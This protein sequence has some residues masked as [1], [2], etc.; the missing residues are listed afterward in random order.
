VV[1][2]VDDHEE[3]A[4]YGTLEGY[5]KAGASKTAESCGNSRAHL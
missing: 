5:L 2:S 1:W 3:V 4:F